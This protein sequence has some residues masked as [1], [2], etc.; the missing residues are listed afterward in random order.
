[1]REFHNFDS[2][3][4]QRMWIQKHVWEDGNMN[5]L[6]LIT[7]NERQVRKRKGSSMLQVS[8]GLL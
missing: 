2:D 7:R 3:T 5:A 8:T 6:Y 4:F 1:M